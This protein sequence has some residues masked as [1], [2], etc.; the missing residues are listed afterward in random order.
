M[1]N[2][3]KVHLP[4][5]EDYV[6][7][8]RRIWE[9]GRVTNHG[10][11]VQELESRLCGY[12]GVPH[13]IV[14][15]NGTLAL[16]IALRA[17]RV[18]GSIVTTPFS[19]VA[20]TSAPAW[21]GIAPVFADIDASL[22]IDPAQVEAVWREDTGGILATHVYGN[23][24][25]VEALARIARAKGVP[26]IYDAAH[27]FGARLNGKALCA[28]GDVAVLS[29]H[30]TKLFHTGEG[31]ALVTHS[32]E[33]AQRIQALR[34]L[35]QTSPESFEGV[36]TN[37]KLSEL[38]AAMG[39]C[40]L[41]AVEQLIR[42]SQ[43]A[44]ASYDQALAGLGLVQ[45]AWAAGLLRSYAYYPVLFKTTGDLLKVRDALQA[46]NVFPRRDF[47]P[48]L[49]S[50]SYVQPGQAT[51]Y[52]DDVCARVLCL[53]LWAEIESEQIKRIS[54]IVRHALT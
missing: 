14:V 33:L 5:I 30:A 52:C 41:P 20:T 53:P 39:L 15:A 11:L 19:Y 50:L 29:F 31:G 25:D 46:E 37:A 2:V 6:A 4:P 35:G 27:A 28:Y 26:L 10:P 34:N 22:C 40:M 51:P 32:A 8:L 18:T 42:Q 36:G 3:T 49:S 47:Y 1:I 13:V 45:P 43:A 21:E 38:H 16:H 54:E 17:C 12:L 48:S 7:L 9:S 23:A 44:V 24:C